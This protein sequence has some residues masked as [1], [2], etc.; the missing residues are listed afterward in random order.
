MNTWFTSDT[1]FFHRGAAER[2]RP[3]FMGDVGHMNHVLIEHWNHGPIKPNDLVYHLGDF[4][5]GR[6]EQTLEVIGRLKGRIHLIKGNHDHTSKW[7]AWLKSQF[8]GI[9]RMME[10]KV[11]GHPTTICHF[12]MRQ[13]NKSHYG[14]FHLHG[15][16][17]G[18]LEP[19][20]RAM[21][22]GC[23]TK[24]YQLYHEEEVHAL[25][26]A[27]DIHGHKDHHS[28]REDML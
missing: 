1:H 23:D 24:P 20:G 15:H 19:Y 8:M 27:R 14:A 25:L 2:F 13:W 5:F 9:D 21:D 7:P 28:I 11:C 16:C 12:P 22:V 6:P 18:N 3:S 4:S 26:M 10:I 17:H